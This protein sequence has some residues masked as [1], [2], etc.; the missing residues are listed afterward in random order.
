ML[1]VKDILR[2]ISAIVGYRMD[3]IFTKIGE[4]KAQQLDGK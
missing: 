4:E 2:Q 1:I 3:T